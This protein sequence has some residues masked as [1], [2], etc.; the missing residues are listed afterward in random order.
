MKEIT[1]ASLA[2]LRG[3]IKDKMSGKRLY[4]TLAVEAMTARLCALFCPE[5]TQKMRAAALLHDLT[6]EV[7]FE[8]Q[9]QLCK[10]YGIPLG[11]TDLASPKTLHARTAAALIP[12]EFPDFDDPMIINAVRWHTTGRAA[13]SVTEQ[14]LYL[15]DYI[16][17]SRTFA[18]CVELRDYFWSANPESMG[19]GARRAHFCRT[20][21]RSF[22]MTVADLIAE[23][24]PVAAD[25][26]EARNARLIEVKRLE[27]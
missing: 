13:S 9:K 24:L 3:I 25:T 7:G 22:D 17:D 10:Q 5:Y 27:G 19:F 21:V 2:E 4:H 8:E 18:A 12:I 6:K 20:L 15:A 14:I 16:D 11:D 23:G 1:D 26:I